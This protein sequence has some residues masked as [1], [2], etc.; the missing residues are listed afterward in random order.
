[1]FN[2]L[3]LM[4]FTALDDVTGF[5][6]KIAGYIWSMPLVI[7]LV[8]TGVYFS[9]RL[10]FPQFR[11]I[12]HSIAITRGKY[13]DPTDPG[14]ITHFQA[15]CAAL[16][17]TVGVGNIAGV[18][19]ALHAGGPGALFW[20]W[21][22]A[23]FGMVTKYAECTL[24]QKYRVVHSDG[25]VSGGPMYYIEKG[26]GKNFK[27][28]AV[29]FATCGLIATFGGGNMVQSNS[30]TIAFIDQFATQKFYNDT[31]LSKL[32]KGMGVGTIEGADFLIR[33]SDGRTLAIDISN[34][35]TVGDLLHTINNHPENY[36]RF[37]IAEIATDHNSID[38]TDLTHG[39]YEFT[40]AS[41]GDSKFIEELGFI[42][43]D[44][45]INKVDDIKIATFIPEK[46]F[47][48]AM[49]GVAISVIVGL[50]IIGGIRRIGKVASKLVPFMSSV[51]V[52]GAL[53]II[54]WN[55]TKIPDAFYLIIKHAFT[56]T[57]AVGGFAGA[58]V[59]YTITW[60]VKRAAFSNE[61]GLGSAPIA[62]AAAK[63]K[64]P[65]RE[66]LVA[67]MEPLV[68]TLIICTMTAL[69]II[70]TGE[71]TSK[72][73]SSVLT[74]NAFSAGIPYF[75]GFIVS[76]GLILFA[77]STAISW[78]YYGD[79]CAEYL[80]G[81]AAI[82]PYRWVYVLALFVGAIVQ[83][84][85]VWNFS[86]ITLGLMALPNLIALIALSGVVIGLTKDYFSRKHIRTK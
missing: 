84:E 71:W 82:M 13:D 12:G 9:I 77:I 34:A 20:M 56:P 21:V 62:H 45:S 60:G 66:G 2:T 23:F 29:L 8:G 37:I 32:N 4:N 68:D 1:M 48:R 55:F 64:E 50:V 35:R 86:D 46:F 18:A 81:P 72:A 58:T 61:A 78:S 22:S 11:R 5:L 83:L 31:P 10:V 69:V 14:D 27:W 47:L 42:N 24:A 85:F 63:T 36:P 70:I 17:A 43:D 52:A 51:Y 40:L 3:P 7:L 39:V 59:L 80:F 19:T 54:L 26:L 57:A 74:K 79:R 16:S 33:S 75:G 38:I 53:F 41:P 67:M 30:M 25:S 15:L 73:D 49:I 44:G 65:V 28:L 6:G 76:L